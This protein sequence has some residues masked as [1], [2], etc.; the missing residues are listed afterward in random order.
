MLQQV[1]YL[2]HDSLCICELFYFRF[3]MIYILP[4]DLRGSQQGGVLISAKREIML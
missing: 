4:E 2:Q 3:A 1:T